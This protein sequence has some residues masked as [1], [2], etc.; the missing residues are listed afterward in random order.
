[1]PRKG[2][3]GETGDRET[4]GEAN[5]IGLGKD[6]WDLNLR[7]GGGKH[8]QEMYLTCR[9]SRMRGE[10]KASVTLSSLSKFHEPGWGI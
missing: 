6:G 9:V 2:E 3:R 10:K 4:P 8:N 5:A 7:G 1:M